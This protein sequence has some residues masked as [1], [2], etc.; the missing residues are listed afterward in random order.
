MAS[1]C[2]IVVIQTLV[3]RQ[4]KFNNVGDRHSR[5]NQAEGKPDRI[6]GGYGGSRRDLWEDDTPWGL[7]GGMDLL[8]ACGE[9]R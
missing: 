7:G 1:L 8:A 4:R 9:P 3:K 5:S 2:T 6:E